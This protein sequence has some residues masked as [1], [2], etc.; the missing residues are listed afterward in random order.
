MVLLF[1]LPLV[2]AADSGCSQPGRVVAH[3][4]W[5]SIRTPPFPDSTDARDATAYAVDPGNSNRLL[6]TNGSSLMFTKDGGCVWTHVFSVPTQPADVMDS[7][8]RGTQMTLEYL[9][10]GVGGQG[11]LVMVGEQTS[12]DSLTAESSGDG[13]QWQPARGLPLQGLVRALAVSPNTVGVAYLLID[14]DLYATSDSGSTWTLAAQLPFEM[15]SLK[16]D[17]IDPNQLWGWTRTTMYHLTS[18]GAVL[19]SYSPA[20]GGVATIDVGHMPDKLARVLVFGENGAVSQSLDG[21]NT[22]NSVAGFSSIVTSAGHSAEARDRSLVTTGD[23]V[24]WRT[25][26]FTWADV[27]PDSASSFDD[28]QIAGP[29]GFVRTEDGLEFRVLLDPNNV[30][31]DEGPVRTGIP[32]GFLGPPEPPGV[33]P[34]NGTVRVTAGHN[35]TVTYNVFV[36]HRFTPIDLYFLADTTG[37]T[38]SVIEPLQKSIGSIVKGLKLAD[39]DARVGLGAF[40]D[41]AVKPYGDPGDYPYRRLR[42]LGPLDDALTKAIDGIETGGG[43]DDDE[44]Q[45]AALYQ[46]ATGDGQ[47]APATPLYIAPHQQA[48]FRPAAER[49]VMLGTDAPFHR[50]DTDPTYPGP[51]LAATVDA[52]RARNIKVVGLAMDAEAKAGLKELARATGAVASSDLDCNGDGESEVRAGG[53]IVCS[54]SA[55]GGDVTAPVLNAIAAVQEGAALN[56]TATGAGNVVRSV[57]PTTFGNIG[58]GIDHTLPLA[59]TF[60]CEVAQVGGLFP[61]TI[62]ATLGSAPLTHTAA[63]VECLPATRAAPP[64]VRTAAL[65]PKPLTNQ[66]PATPPPPAPV[67]SANYAPQVNANMQPT[68]GSQEQQRAQVMMATTDGRAASGDVELAFSLAAAAMGAGALVWNDRTRQRITVRR[69]R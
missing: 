57:T 52:L 63:T 29:R 67:S 7:S 32:P 8:A 35:V 20:S 66:N 4:A 65:P 30:D 10:T 36:P 9:A 5:T 14:H 25:P 64:P 2:V 18:N 50:S 37:S 58:T 56:A 27:T 40:R 6:I 17:D 53:S 62:A 68:M 54:I 46:T 21:G 28:V 69:T 3:G 1:A 22:Y 34:A 45:L 11:Y 19:S 43:G 41:Y 26:D 48:S 24:K 44:S 39:I 60:G 12:G 31:V 13:T 33:V 16:V 47:G 49:V 59:V 23:R 61:V 38:A 42:D 51:S 55:D 15:S